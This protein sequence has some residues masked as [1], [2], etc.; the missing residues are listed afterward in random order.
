MKMAG[1]REEKKFKNRC[2]DPGAPGRLS[3]DGWM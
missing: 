2:D 3:G 1:W